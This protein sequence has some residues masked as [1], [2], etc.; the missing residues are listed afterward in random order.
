MSPER[1]HEICRSLFRESNDA[2]FVFDPAVLWIVD[3]NPAALRL[4]GSAART[5]SRC[6]WTTCSVRPTRRA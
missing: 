6:G 5:R 3:L 4:T 1:Q 2:F